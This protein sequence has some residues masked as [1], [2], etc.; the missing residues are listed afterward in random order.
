MVRRLGFTKAFTII[1]FA[2][3]TATGFWIARAAGER[4]EIIDP[5]QEAGNTAHRSDD[6]RHN[7][8]LRARAQAVRLAN[9]Q[10]EQPAMSWVLSSDAF[11]HLSS[12]SQQY[13]ADKFQL[14]PQSED[15]T[16]APLAI[17]SAATATI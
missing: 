8:K 16:I 6:L 5:S 1:L 12:T 9:E 15:E 4:S 7:R 17:E 11:D 2:I 14:E 10:R 3:F 13:F